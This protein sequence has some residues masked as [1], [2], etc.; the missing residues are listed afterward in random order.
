MRL[1]TTEERE[2]DETLDAIDGPKLPVPILIGIVIVG[3][4]IAFV[5]WAVEAKGASPVI[6]S[7]A[8]ERVDLVEV[9]HYYDEN[10]TLL[11]DQ[12][13][14]YDWCDVTGRYQV[15]GWRLLKKASE[16]PR[17]EP[18]GYSLTL[19]EGRIEARKYR[20]SWTQHD[21]ELTERKWLPSDERRELFARK[22]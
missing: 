10:G 13:I 9:N 15:R 1:T 16:Y 17:T 12:A 2:M 20:E 19:R 14:L 18:E 4:L 21:P 11:L 8:V 22:R 7:L 3:I 5:V 6:V